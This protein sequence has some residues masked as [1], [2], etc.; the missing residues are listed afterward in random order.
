M[1]VDT[2]SLS[3]KNKKMGEM[4]EPEINQS[5]KSKPLNVKQ[6]LDGQFT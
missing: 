6:D 2:Y 4:T 1:L 3:Q 5:H